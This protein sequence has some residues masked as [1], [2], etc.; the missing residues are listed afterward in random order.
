MDRWMNEIKIG[1]HLHGFDNL[2]INMSDEPHIILNIDLN[3]PHNY[4][5][6]EKDKIM[7]SDN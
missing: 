7:L 4:F 2:Y 1:H 3:Y 6:P 5:E